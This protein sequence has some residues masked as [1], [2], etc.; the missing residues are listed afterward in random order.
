MAL[1]EEALHSTALKNVFLQNT[2]LRVK[3]DSLEVRGEE[4]GVRG[5]EE[6]GEAGGRG[7][8]GQGRQGVRKE[9]LS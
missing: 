2:T 4:C 5:A 6:A 1:V 3:M 9:V 8:R 7:G